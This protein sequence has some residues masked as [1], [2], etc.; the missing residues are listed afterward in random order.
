MDIESIDFSEMSQGELK[1]VAARCL[2]RIENPDKGIG[3][4][5]FEA[6]LKVVPQPC[7]ELAV[8]DQI[9]NPRRIFLTWK[10]CG[11]YLGWHCPG[12][13]FKFGQTDESLIKKTIQRELGETTSVAG[14][15]I[16][17]GN[18][19]YNNVCEERGHVFGNIVSVKLGS[20]PRINPEK[21]KWF[22]IHNLPNDLLKHHKKFLKKAYGWR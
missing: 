3:T 7:F 16:I 22:D 1:E 12:S 13:F 18:G 9:R 5:L 20:I 2:E 11:N 17:G 14:F 15:E 19:R 8:L 4:R 21:G 6:S 10:D